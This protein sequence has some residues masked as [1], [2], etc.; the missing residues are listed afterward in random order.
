MTVLGG[1]AAFGHHQMEAAVH[2]VRG[3]VAH[4]EP[5]TAWLLFDYYGR[6]WT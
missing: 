6:W 4:L 1:L 5:F 2:H 3:P